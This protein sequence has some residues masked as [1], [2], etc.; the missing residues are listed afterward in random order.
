MKAEAGAICYLGTAA[1]DLNL[2]VFSL[3]ES[4]EMHLQEVTDLPG[5]LSWDA[6][7]EKRRVILS[8]RVVGGSRTK[9]CSSGL[10]HGS[11][12]TCSLGSSLCK[13][14]ELWNDPEASLK[15]RLGPATEEGGAHCSRSS[16]LERGYTSLRSCIGAT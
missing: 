10:R 7:A 14:K 15:E 4:P 8:R 16:E 12:A 5:S 11:L 2:H 13:A 9:I 3:L 6:A 1:G